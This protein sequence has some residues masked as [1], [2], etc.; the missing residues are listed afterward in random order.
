MVVKVKIVG[1]DLFCG[2]GG[3]THGLQKAGID[4][5]AGFDIEVNCKFPYEHNNSAEFVLKSVVDITA[6]DIK[7]RFDDGA[8]SLLAGCAPCQ[9]FS[10]YTQAK[11]K[12][13]DE[14]WGLLYQ[15]ARLVKESQPDF[16]TMENVPDLN[17]H[18]VYTDFKEELKSEG[19]FVYERVVFCPDYGMAQ[20]RSR[21]VLLASRLGSIELIK[22][23]HDKSKYI[24]VKDVIGHLPKIKSGSVNKHDPLHR[25]SGLSELNLMRIK[26]SKPGGTWR[27]WPEELRAKCHTKASGKGYASVYGRMAWDEPSPTI[28]T[29]CFGF[30]NGRFGHPT[31]ARAIS[32]REAAILQSF[33]DDYEFVEPDGVYVMKNL[34]KMIGNAVPVRLGEIVGISLQNHINQQPNQ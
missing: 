16:I 5:K 19:Y 8:Y 3:L 12:D 29:Q 4:V 17:K 27:D 14:R 11:P 7:S 33:P 34:G 21:L 13:Q 28:T 10:K 31:Q 22:P 9:P 26:A 6:E 18:K 15:F 20:T 25:S 24:T 1:V 2:A 32:L 30:G 23:T